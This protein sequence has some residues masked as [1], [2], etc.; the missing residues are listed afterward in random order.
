M[1]LVLSG[2]IAWAAPQ[3]FEKAGVAFMQKH[4][5]SCHGRE[6]KKGDVALHEFNDAASL[7]KARKKWKGILNAVEQHDMPPDDEPQPKDEE[8]RVFLESARAVF[9]EFD[10][11]AKPDPGRVTLRRL[12]RVEYNNTIRDLTGLDF[13]PAANFPS[14]DVGYGFDNIGDVLSVSPVLMERYLDAASTIAEM[15][16][17]AELPKPNKRHMPARFTEP[18]A[19]GVP[20]RGE[21][22]MFTPGK[23]HVGTG[24]LNTPFTPAPDSE[25]VF[26][27]RVYAE[28]PSGRPVRIAMIVAGPQI[29][30]PE[31]DK[32]AGLEIEKVGQVANFRVL[33]EVEVTARSERDAQTFEVKMPRIKGIERIAVAI[34]RDSAA[35]P[36]PTVFLRFLEAEGPLDRGTQFMKRYMGGLDGKPPRDQVRQVLTHFMSRAWRRPVLAD[37]IERVA[38]VADATIAGGADINAGIRQA[39]IGVLASPKFIF[40]MEPDTEP[41]NPEAH[42]VS[43]FQLA[44]RLSYFLWST[45]P[46]EE[47]FKLAG[48]RKLTASLDSQVRRMLKDPRA[49]ALV[50]NFGIQWLQLRRLATHQADE[51]VF[52]RW[53]PSLRNSMLEE[54]R[55]FLN[56]IVREDRS[57]L[58][59]LDGD[60][61]YIDRRLSEVYGIYPPGGFQGDA[62]RRVS[63]AGTPRGGLLTQ[64]SILTVS[65]NPTRT[66]PVKRGKWVLEQ[67]LG[68]PPPPAPPNVPSIDD[69][70]R[71]ELSGTFRQKM[72]QHRADPKCGNCHAKMDTIGF[73]MENFDGIGRWRDKDE[74]NRP[75][76]IGDKVPGLELHSLAELKT[77]LKNQRTQFGRC[78]AEKML[79]YATGRGLEYYDDRTI[80][81]I[82]A[83]LEKENWRFS[84]LITAIAKSD[85]FRLRRGTSQK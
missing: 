2:A 83:T 13:Q 84:A 67:I 80:D 72:M 43:E 85:P 17:P 12:N 6:K 73:A 49:T 7:L 41:E 69:G 30:N 5:I 77:M 70:N 79:I 74:Q 10:K 55:L 52:K 54:T 51:S 18:G 60:F 50:E 29:E 26:R 75:L 63:L 71:K 62:F 66:S 15:A 65:S 36:P 22:R 25:Y 78:V 1:V 82:V 40:R 35:N 57:I 64:G 38:S 24:P 9:A 14:D 33:R 16:L 59:M 27:T 28:S 20:M 19:V 81:T 47:L 56:E 34:V 76:E 4:C 45:M 31:K 32:A 68:D 3:S 61:T 44:T 48:E 46:D 37:E 39:V 42:P 58:D 21:W 8:R 11:N 53:R 23:D